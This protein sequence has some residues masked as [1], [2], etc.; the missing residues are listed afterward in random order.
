MIPAGASA[1]ELLLFD[2]EARAAILR[3]ARLG[4]LGADGTL[5]T[6]ADH[7]DAGGLDALRD[8]VVHRRARTALTQTE[9]VLVGAALVAVAFD[10]HELIAVLLEPRGV[11]VEDAPVR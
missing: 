8:E 9:V 2:Q 4:L 7:R 11:R 6:I 3:P 1:E 10:Q 5:F